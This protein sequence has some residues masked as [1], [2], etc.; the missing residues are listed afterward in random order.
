M[1]QENTITENWLTALGYDS[2]TGAVRI[3]VNLDSHSG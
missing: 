3:P 1:N 2:S